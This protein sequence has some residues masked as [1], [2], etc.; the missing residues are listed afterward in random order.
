MKAGEPAVPIVPVALP[1]SRSRIGAYI[2]L[3]RLRQWLKN[4][5]VLAGLFFSDQLFE[6][7]TAIHSLVATLA[8][9]LVSSAVYCINDVLDRE[10]DA[11]HP[12]KQHRPLASGV[13]TPAAAVRAAVLLVAAAGVMVAAIRPPAAVPLILAAYLA[14][15][16]AYSYRLKHV[17]I[18][19]VSII[20]AGFVLRLVAGT[21]AVDV[22]PSSWIVLCT[23]LLSLFLALGKRR[24]DLER[25]DAANRASLDGYTIAFVDQALS[26]MAAAT[27]VVYALFT[28]SDYAQARFD[29]PLLYL[30]TFPVAIGILRYLQ[31]VLVHGRYGSPA[32]LAAQDRV[33]QLIVIAWIGLFFVFVYG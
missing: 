32:D 3:F 23:G 17:A 26:T 7:Q 31:M 24:G 1:V 13:L 21:Y 15:N 20:A 27:I 16:L 18:V 12:E 22:T 9:C 4:G 33:L 19:D 29:A 5:F 10:A 30:T 28:V 6:A 2:S 14:L 11:V 8:F 25:E